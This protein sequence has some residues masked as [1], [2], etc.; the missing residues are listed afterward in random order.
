MAEKKPFSDEELQGL[1]QG[2]FRLT[3]KFSGEIVANWIDRFLATIAAREQERDNYLESAKLYLKNS[4]YYSG[5]L[6]EIAKNFGDAAFISDDSSVQDS[7]L[8]AKMPELVQRQAAM[9]GRMRG[10]MKK[11]KQKV[12]RVV[13]KPPEGP[14]APIMLANVIVAIMG[15]VDEALDTKG[16]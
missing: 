16:E 5:L 8:R 10:N 14:T 7:P 6:D 1:K 12:E 4:D 11:V 2:N 15:I 9:I 3:E 13:K